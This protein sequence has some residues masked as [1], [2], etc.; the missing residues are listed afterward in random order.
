MI[1]GFKHYKDRDS[2]NIK[3]YNSASIDHINEKGDR[4]VLRL[5]E[6]SDDKGESIKAIIS[7]NNKFETAVIKIESPTKNVIKNIRRILA[8]TLS[9]ALSPRNLNFSDNHFNVTE[10]VDEKEKE[11]SS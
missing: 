4:V 6:L 10:T 5:G 3:W 9:N 1:V 11:N 8:I 2:K 7:Y